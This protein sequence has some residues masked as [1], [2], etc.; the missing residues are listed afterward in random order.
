MTDTAPRIRVT[1]VWVQILDDLEPAWEEEGEFRFEARV[2]CDGDVQETRMP[3]SGTFAIM[4]HPAWNRRRINQVIYEGEAGERMV[5][6]LRGY[7]ED[8]LTADD[9]LEAYSREF[10]GDSAAWPG[11]YCPG[12]EGAD[13]PENMSNWRIC[14]TVELVED[15]GE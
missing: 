4:D 6:E 8:I 10:T 3:D 12:D 5:V 14:Y 7:E 9:E 1:L 13:D 15:D 2:E 11:R